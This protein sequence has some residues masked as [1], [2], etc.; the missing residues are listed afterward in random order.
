MTRPAP[1]Y[2]AYISLSFS[3]ETIHMSNKVKT[4]RGPKGHNFASEYLNLEGKMLINKHKLGT[5]CY[6]FWPPVNFVK[7]RSAFA[8]ISL[9]CLNQSGQ[10]SWISKRPWKTQIGRGRWYLASSQVLLNLFSRNAEKELII[11]SVNQRP[12]RPFRFF[13]RSAQKHKLDRGRCYPAS[14]QISL[15]SA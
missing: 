12:G 5:G 10:P 15:N 7:F 2:S 14:C 3:Y 8:E 9:N 13:F 6:A 1:L 4:T 11:V